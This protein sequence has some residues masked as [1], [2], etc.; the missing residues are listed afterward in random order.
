MKHQRY[1]NQRCTPYP[2][3]VMADV[4]PVLTAHQA[5]RPSPVLPITGQLPIA[6]SCLLLGP[7]YCRSVT[8][9]QVLPMISTMC[10]IISL[11]FTTTVKHLVV[12]SPL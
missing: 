11:V 4:S 12:V 7:T 5:S 10:V 6:G 2:I 8:Y 9:H 3:R 1:R